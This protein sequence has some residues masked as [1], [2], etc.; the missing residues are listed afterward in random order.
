VEPDTGD[1]SLVLFVCAA[2]VCRSPFAEFTTW[3][4]FHEHG[5]RQPWTLI[6]AGTKAQA[7]QR[8][9]ADVAAAAETLP[10]GADFARSHRSRLLD[11]ELVENAGLI[12]VSSQKERSAVARISPSA[13][14]RTFTMIETALLA[15]SAVARGMTLPEGTALSEVSGT[16]HLNRGAIANE[17]RPTLGR[18]LG[19]RL[20]ERPT[21]LDVHDVHLGEI[22]THGPVVA[23]LQWTAE[24]L[25]QAM[26]SLINPSPHAL[27]AHSA[28]TP[29]GFLPAQEPALAR[30]RP[31]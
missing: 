6:S 26:S 28:R 2:N 7:G 29:P 18:R 1:R 14:A 16:L 25:A 13:R 17:A 24:H 8:M 30:R 12:L 9:C 10:G 23:D 21:G 31:R 20:T 4:R 27:A 3:L 19:R 15:E 11:A 22:K 5:V